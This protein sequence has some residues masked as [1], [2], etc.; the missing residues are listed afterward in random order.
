MLKINPAEQIN[1][2]LYLQQYLIW[3][4]QKNFYSQ[5]QDPVVDICNNGVESY[6]YTQINDINNSTAPVVIIDNLSESIHSL[7]MFKQYRKDCK[8]L[9]FTAG[10]WDRAYHDLDL[11]YEIIYTPY[12]VYEMADSY[13][14][15]QRFCFYLDKIYTFDYPKPYKFVSTIGTTRIVRD[16]LV[17]RLLEQVTDPN[18][19]IRYSRQDLK[20]SGKDYDVIPFARGSFDPYTSLIDK[21]YHNVSQTL[22]IKL[23]NQAYFNLI[24]ESDVDINHAFFITEKTIKGLITGM[25]FVSVASANFLY[26]VQQLGFKTYNTIWDESYDQIEDYCERVDAVV[27]LC[28]HLCSLDWNK[29]REELQQIANHNRLNFLNLNCQADLE[30]QN[31]E[32]IIEKL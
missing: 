6:H 9:I 14:S 28:N 10:T 32:S 5:Q 24:V 25:P 22:P 11:D 2:R 31:F 3:R 13:L 17:N 18:V 4:D 20:A 19:I 12:F 1:L 8:Y 21:Y 16:Y 26:N 23:Y 7:H 29:H 30:F 15:P 27:A